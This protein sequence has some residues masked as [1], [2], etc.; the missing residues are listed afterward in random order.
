M[1]FPPEE[2]E[3]ERKITDHMVGVKGNRLKYE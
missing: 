3:K 1:K 2:Y